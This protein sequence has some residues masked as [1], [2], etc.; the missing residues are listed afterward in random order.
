MRIAL[1]TDAYL[2]QVGGVS[3][4][5]SLLKEALTDRGHTVYVFTT[6][7]P[8]QPDYEDHVI[9]V[10]SLPFLSSKRVASHYNPL[11]MSRVCDLDLD[12]IHTH[13]EFGLGIFG[14]SAA[15][16]W[17]IPYMHSYHTIYEEWL[18]GQ[19]K[20][21]R[22]G[23]LDHFF[24]D[25]VALH[26]RVFCNRALVIV[27]PSVKTEHLLRSYGVTRPIRVL[28]TGIDLT[29]F[30]Q[31]KE[32][33]E[34]RSR[35]RRELGYGPEHKLLLSL[36][37]IS[38]EKGIDELLDDLAPFLLQ[39]P[40]LRFLIV[41]EGPQ[42]GS[43]ERQAKRLG[44][45]DKVRFYGAVPMGD[46]PR[47]YAAADLF[48]SASRSE[49]QGLVYIEALATGLPVLV[50]R[51]DCLRGVVSEGENGYFF[52]EQATFA[53]R[54]KDLL[55]LDPA[56]YKRFSERAAASAERFSV[57]NFAES[58]EAVYKKLPELNRLRMEERAARARAK[59]GPS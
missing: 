52:E 54:L 55:N 35:L 24:R 8:A 40:E 12:V 17:N 23:K 44:V 53:A 38:Q 14:R 20:A 6:T 18:R 34:A 13:T 49:T 16:R 5:V 57:A 7:D 48:L 41:G 15:K 21:P 45:A 3:T 36:G 42:R 4:S 1:F 51:D 39:Q 50:R 22:D 43:L 47:F 29:R 58:M 56:A 30:R 19:F 26:S 37:R 27:A 10:P 31:A 33:G 59:A 25:C 11:L 2:P 9:R 28:P 46:V 32:D